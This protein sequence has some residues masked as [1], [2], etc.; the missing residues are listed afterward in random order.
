M[1][2]FK[3]F[4]ANDPSKEAISKTEAS[5]LEEAINFFVAEKKLDRESFLRIFSV[6]QY[7]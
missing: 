4:S 7:K 3:S 1:S 6:E 5:N 2:K